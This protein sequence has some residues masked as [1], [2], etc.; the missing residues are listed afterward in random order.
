MMKRA[1]DILTSD[2]FTY[3]EVERPTS[4]P[5]FQT[6]L[7]T[8]P[9]VEALEH[10]IADERGAYLY[11]RGNNPTVEAV[12]EKV[13]ALEGAERAK[14]FSSGVAAIAASILSLVQ[15]GDHIIIANDAYTWA[16]YI[17][18]T[19]L[20]R[21]GVSAT[22]VDAT[23]LDAVEEAITA[24]TKVL[25][26]ESPGTLYLKV[27]DLRALASLAKAHQITTII[28]NTW[29]TPIYQRP[30]ELGIDLSVHSASKYLGGHSDLVGGVVAGS[31]EQIDHIFRTEF[32]PIGHVPD[33]HQ[34]WLIHR[35]MRTMAVRL[36][37]HYQSALSVGDFLLDHPA[38]AQLYYP[39]HPKS[40]D[41]PLA[42]SQMSG[43]S[44]LLSVRLKS[45]DRAKISQAVN[46]LEHFRI[47][48]SWGGYESLVFASLT[49]K[50]GDVSMLRLHIGLEDTDT[51]IEDLEEA[52]ACL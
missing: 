12:E 47:G 9:T 6:S 27:Q 19:Y 28:D 3:P 15:S 29:A 50:D 21:F 7:F 10:A 4:V 2:I 17:T 13:A 18:T 44:G 41:Y 30:L 11:S 36:A 33:P 48:V 52:F 51:L 5:L 42:S 14:L 49:T 8:F 32:L 46:T 38:V 24:Q 25:Y 20:A 31:S 39:M 16:Q 23:D 45:T 40:P 1:S 34:A 43:G 26:L 35:G 22:L 37:H